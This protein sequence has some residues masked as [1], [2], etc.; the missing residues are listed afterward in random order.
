MKQHTARLIP[1][2]CGTVSRGPKCFA[3]SEDEVPRSAGT[4]MDAGLDGDR[5]AAPGIILGCQATWGGPDTPAA[6]NPTHHR[7]ATVQGNPFPQARIPCPSSPQ[8]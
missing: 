5:G 3:R 4:T 7:G 8:P 2:C 1:W 6:P